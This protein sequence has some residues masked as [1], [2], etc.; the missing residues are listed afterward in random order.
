MGEQ[1]SSLEPT[2]TPDADA[3]VLIK[4]GGFPF[5]LA[6]ICDQGIMAERAWAIPHR[7]EARLGHL[8]PARIAADPGAVLAAFEEP[9]SLH[10]FNPTVAAWVVAAAERVLAEYGGDAERIW[11]DE[12]TAVELIRRLGAFK[13]IGQKKAAMAVEILARDLK[14]PITDFAGSDIAYDVHVRRVMMRT[15]LAERDEV[16]HMVAV[17][18]DLFPARPACWTS[19]CGTWGGTG[20][21][22]GCRTAR[23]ARSRRFARS[24]SRAATS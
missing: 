6:V 15:G 10:R 12:P 14:R 18:R 20:A 2:F 13:G 23:R 21:T 17:A 9:P 8:D 3:D 19:P 7:L 5:L 1:I 4:R 24:S 16:G 22:R 11:S